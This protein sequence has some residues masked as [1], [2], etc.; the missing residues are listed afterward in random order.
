MH[1][2]SADNGK[3]VSAVTNWAIGDLEKKKQVIIEVSDVSL[4][5]PVDVYIKSPSSP[6]LSVQLP[7]GSMAGLSVKQTDRDIYTSRI[8]PE[9]EG[10]FL[11]K[12]VSTN[13]QDQDGYSVNY[14]IEYGQLGINTKD[15]KDIAGYTSGRVYNSSQTQELIDDAVAYIRA[16]SL[17]ETKE[18]QMVAVYFVIAALSLYFIDT[19]VRRVNELKRLK[20]E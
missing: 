7:N 2:Y 19:V 5:D 14:P 18:K 15:L 4:G 12:A 16:K 10:T 11:L 9:N 1:L 17:N 13:G 6:Q 3:V 20:K 8:T